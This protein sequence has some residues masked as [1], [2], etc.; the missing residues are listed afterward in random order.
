M[1]KLGKSYLLEIRIDK[2]YNGS[3]GTDMK[4]QDKTWLAC[5]IDTEGSIIVQI[6]DSKKDQRTFSISIRPALK[7]GMTTP[8]LL[9]KAQKLVG[10]YLRGPYRLRKSMVFDWSLRGFSKAIPVL[11]LISPYLLEKKDKAIILIELGKLYQRLLSRP[12]RYPR[13]DRLQIKRKRLANRETKFLLK[14][15]IKKWYPKFGKHTISFQKAKRLLAELKE[16]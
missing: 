15:L 1:A 5:L 11:K 8:N 2:S 6:E 16:E 13:K 14:F 3:G 9:N 7:C 4:I 10:G 12:L